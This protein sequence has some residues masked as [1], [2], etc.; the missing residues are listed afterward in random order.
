[1]IPS[2]GAE[3][4]S[5]RSSHHMRLSIMQVQPAEEQPRLSTFTQSANIH[6]TS[7]GRRYCQ[8]WKWAGQ[9]T[10]ARQQTRPGQ[11]QQQ[12]SKIQLS[13]KCKLWKQNRM[14][15]RTWSMEYAD[16]EY[17]V[18]DSDDEVSSPPPLPSLSSSYSQAPSP[19][20]S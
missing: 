8:R 17:V 13:A 18:S 1:M 2:A 3:K 9:R 6:N 5:H 20:S 11:Q 16:G 15:A 10:V 12:Q 7:V 19:R 4:R 14:A